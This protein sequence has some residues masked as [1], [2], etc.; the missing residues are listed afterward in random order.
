MNYV[1]KKK[2]LNLDLYKGDCNNQNILHHA[3]LLKQKK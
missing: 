2:K 3:V 1:E